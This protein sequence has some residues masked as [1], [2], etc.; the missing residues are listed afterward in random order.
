MIV[1]RIPAK[2]TDRH[3][4]SGRAKHVRDLVDYM[5]SPD[6]ESPLKEYLVAYMASHSSDGPERLIH[7]GARNFVCND[8]DSQR[9]EMMAMA[10]AAVKSPNPIDHWLLSW[11]EGEIP[12]KEEVDAAIEMFVEELGLPKHQCIYAVHGDTHNRHVHVALN[13]FNVETGKMTTINKGYYRNAGHKAVARIIDRFG[14]QPEPNARYV[15][16]DG[17]PV[18]SAAAEAK[19]A[20]GERSLRMGAAAFEVR[21]GYRSAQRIAQEEALP[22]LESAR[23]WS[24]VHARL[25]ERGVAYDP[26]GTNGALFTVANERVKSSDVSR[27]AS[28][29]S[30]E[31]RLGAFEPR[32][33]DVAIGRRRT[34]DD[35]FPGAFR[36]DE[37]LNERHQWQ[38]A[39]KD[40][41]K[42]LGLRR[43]AADLETWLHEQ[44]ES[45]FGERWRQRLPSLDDMDLLGGQVSVTTPP[46]EIDGFRSFHCSDGVR[47]ARHGEG[48]AFIDRGDRVSVLPG[49]DEALLA[50]MKLAVVKFDGKVTVYGTPEMK[51]RTL[52]LAQRHGLAHHLINP[53][54]AL[55]GEK[56]SRMA[57]D[58]ETD[59]RVTAVTHDQPTRER[60]AIP[61]TDHASP[62]SEVL[63]RKAEPPSADDA[64]AGVPAKPGSRQ[65]DTLDQLVL[66]TETSG[67]TK[68]A[69]DRRAAIEALQKL[70]RKPQSLEPPPFDPRPR[71]RGR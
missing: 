31:R 17:E 61:R 34:E 22:I 52:L 13:R 3:A 46:I 48:T 2:P 19:I 12:T 50:A 5:R 64:V 6:K 63:R 39:D 40:E 44:K 55:R 9:A 36:A 47:Y 69:D 16:K 37:Y 66:P 21:T 54:F 26:V 8:L 24:E 35:R 67:E 25:A 11:R 43:P 70:T 59:L 38:R 28:I 1:K 62:N 7:V 65:P 45:R 58:T 27:K 30:L 56:A 51:R 57:P 15:M 14:W 60:E 10:Q 4:G 42:R 20:G 33:A 71:G 18:F 53:E 49:N 23:T 32:D 68:S 29:T 41:R